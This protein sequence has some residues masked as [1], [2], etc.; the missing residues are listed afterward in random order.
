M[1]QNEHAILQV[2]ESNAA[3]AEVV[4]KHLP[5]VAETC[6]EVGVGPFGVGIVGFLSE[7]P[8]RFALDPLEPVSMDALDDEAS[9]PY[10]QIRILVRNVRKPIRYLVGSGE[11]IPVE[12]ETMDLVICCNVIDHASDPDAIL[13]EIYRVLKPGGIFFLDV[14]TFSVLGLIKWHSW[15]KHVHKDEILVKAHPHRMFESNVVRRLRGSGFQVQKISGHSASSNLI[16]HARVSAF[17]G[18]KRSS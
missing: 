18:L 5:P 14:D 2:L 13:R 11:D 3:K 9:S 1:A 15:T 7:I 17:L 10:D 6:L 8:S 4:R 12:K 16:G